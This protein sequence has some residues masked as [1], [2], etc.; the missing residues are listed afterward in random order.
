MPA[1]REPFAALNADPRVMAHFPA[2]LDR[3]QSDATA[4][5]IEG[6]QARYGFCFWALEPVAVEPGTGFLGFVGVQWV[7]EDLPFSPAI[8]IGW[9]LAHAA[10]GQGYAP[11]AARAALD[12]AFAEL[13]VPEVVALA[14]A[15]NSNSR[16]VMEKIGMTYDPAGD[17]DHPRVED[18]RIRPHVLYRIAQPAPR[19]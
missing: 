8:E 19:S 6:H 2:P 3:A 18:P 17:F 13:D 7:P 4:E 12:Y 9:R 15:G 11:E 14:T 5:R 1:D 16:R 10:W